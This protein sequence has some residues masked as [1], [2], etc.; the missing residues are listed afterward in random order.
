ML[1]GVPVQL[2]ALEVAVNR[3]D[4]TFNPTNC[5]RDD[6]RG[7][8]V[9][10]RRR[11]RGPVC[12]VQSGRLRRACRSTRPW[13]PPPRASQQSRRREPD[14]KV[15]SP[16]S[17]CREHP[18]GVPEAPRRSCRRG[19]SR[20]SRT[21]ASRRCSKRTRRAAMK[22]A[23]IGYA[24]VHTPV[25][26][27]P[28]TGPAYLVSHGGAA[29]PDVEFVL[30][31]EGITLVLDGKTDIKKGVTYSRFE[32]APDAPFTTFET[33][34][35]AGPH[36]VLAREHRRSPELRPVRPQ[37]TIPTDDHRPERRGD[38]TG[39][40]DRGHGLR[41][42]QSLQSQA[43]EGAAARQSPQGLQEKETKSKRVACEK[44]ARRRYDPKKKRTRQR[45]PRATAG[46]DSPWGP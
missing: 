40:E 2:K 12:S 39:H 21:R 37:L 16:G 26:K 7:H 36:S 15:T 10:R 41:G 8:P 44:A 3:P 4:F 27:S 32:S 38:R 30:Q 34:L 24:T 18:E 31:G 42:R 20:R 33:V 13:K 6:H 43:H 25:L 28:L 45:R 17:G 19:F 1:K 11:Q 5:E 23:V 46:G 22:T 14:V 35:P 29:F 9:R